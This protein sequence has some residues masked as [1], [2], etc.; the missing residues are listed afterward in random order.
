[1]SLPSSKENSGNKLQKSRESLGEC[2]T[3]FFSHIWRKK[4]QNFSW[5]MKATD[6]FAMSSSKE[7]EWL[8]CQKA[9]KL[10]AEKDILAPQRICHHMLH[11]TC[12]LLPPTTGQKSRKRRKR[13]AVI[14]LR[15]LLVLVNSELS[16]SLA[17]LMWNIDENL[18][19]TLLPCTKHSKFF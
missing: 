3:F 19:F 8:A 9:V 4:I 16:Y 15:M 12:F 13:L 2:P 1:M 10:Q 14:S 18:W 11:I 6:P 17:T 7:K 5:I